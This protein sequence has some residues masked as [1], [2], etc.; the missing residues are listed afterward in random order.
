MKQ[1][2]ISVFF[3]CH[4]IFHSVFVLIAWIKLYRR[5]P[6]FWQLICIFIHDIGH[7]GK[8]YL[9]NI[10]EKKRHWIGGAR[11]AEK[12][13]GIKGFLFIAGHCAYS[14]YKKSELYK[15]DKYSWHIM[16]G[17]FHLIFQTFEPKLKM[18][19]SRM[20][21]IR[22]FKKAVKESIESGEFRSTHDIYLERCREKETRD[23]LR[24]FNSQEKVNQL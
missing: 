6:K 11:L 21:A 23:V 1:G 10:A 13:F 9:D 2:T 4:N 14:G 16:P 17:W 18:G 8:N 7:Y 3:G 22:A 5:L 20:E 19:C 24:G 12:L 15:A